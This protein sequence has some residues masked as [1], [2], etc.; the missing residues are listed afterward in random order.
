MAWVIAGSDSNVHVRI[1]DV[2]MLLIASGPVVINAVCPH[3]LMVPL[4]VAL[5]CRRGRCN[6]IVTD[7]MTT[8]L[9]STGVV[10]LEFF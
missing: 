10:L 2:D 1:S 3:D 4:G 8:S 9:G 5:L 7:T 6:A